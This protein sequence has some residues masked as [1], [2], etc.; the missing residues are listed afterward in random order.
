MY[1]YFIDYALKLIIVFLMTHLV[2]AESKPE[3]NGFHYIKKKRTISSLL[4]S[5]LIK[6]SL[7]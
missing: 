2:F 7:N 4:L 1:Y 3:L 6:C 5:E